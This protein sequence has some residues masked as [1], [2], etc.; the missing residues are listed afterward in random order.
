M[1]FAIALLGQRTCGTAPR[2]QIVVRRLGRKAIRAFVA[3]RGLTA[4]HPTNNKAGLL[5]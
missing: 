4:T 2:A 1:G 3:T 5:S